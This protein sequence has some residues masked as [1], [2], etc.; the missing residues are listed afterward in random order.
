MVLLLES[1]THSTPGLGHKSD[2]PQQD[3]LRGTKVETRIHQRQC[4]HCQRWFWAWD[5]ERKDC[6]VCDAPPPWELK[7]I[8]EG[9]HGAPA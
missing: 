1:G 2:A 4:G 3:A 6:F 5:R 8:L 7:R 9:I